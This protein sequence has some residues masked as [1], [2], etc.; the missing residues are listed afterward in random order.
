MKR[1]NEKNKKKD[2]E[3]STGTKKKLDTGPLVHV[4]GKSRVRARSTKKEKHV[5]PTTS[6]TESGSQSTQTPGDDAEIVANEDIVATLKVK[7]P[8]VPGATLKKTWT[9]E[10]AGR[11]YWATYKHN[12]DDPMKPKFATFCWADGLPNNKTINVAA[13]APAPTPIAG[14]VPYLVMSKADV[15]KFFTTHSTK[16]FGETLQN[17]TDK[18]DQLLASN[19]KNEE[20]SGDESDDSSVGDNGSGESVSEE[21][22]H[23]DKKRKL[24]EAEEK[25]KKEETEH[26]DK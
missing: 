13:P 2:L 25:E 4:T 6:H 3:S 5:P 21:E 19:T 11:Y 1:T 10:N 20:L 9:G 7:A 14:Q 16:L 18:M 8:P 26:P 17:I 23:V 22:K 15:S 12:P 24:N